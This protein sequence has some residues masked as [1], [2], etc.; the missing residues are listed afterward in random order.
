[1]KN[2]FFLKLAKKYRW[3]LS[4]HVL[5][6]V[7]LLTLPPL[8]PL[9][10][11]TIVPSYTMLGI[12]RG[13]FTVSGFLMVLSGS[14]SDRIGERKAILLEFF[15]VPGFLVLMSLSPSYLFLLLFAGGFGLSKILYHPAGLSFLSKSIDEE[16]RGEAI[17]LHESMGNLGAGIAFIAVGSLGGWLGWRPALVLVA[18]PILLLGVSNWLLGGRLGKDVNE[19]VEEDDPPSDDTD[20]SIGKT[21]GVEKEKLSSFYL[22]IVSSVIGGIGF[23][24]FVTFLASFLNQVYGLSTGLAGLLVGSSYLLG[25]FG[26][27][28]GG[29]ISDR[30][31]E[32]LSYTIF[33]VLASVPIMLVVLVD[34]PYFL[35]IPIL[36]AC[37]LLRSLGNP[38]DKSLLAEH[39]S[40]AGRGR[41]YGSLFTSYTLGSFTSGPLFGFL[42]DKF[43]MESAFLLIPVLFVVG[44]VVRYQ[45][46]RYP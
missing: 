7:S 3:L 11:G 14:L 12:L 27:L 28:Y 24:A 10:K 13:V 31:G 4:F 29:R 21:L 41:G 2:G 33:M 40:N 16:S 15:L 37:F 43:R 36:A 26:N 39:S 34:L 25:F 42:I 23:G 17:G 22:Q 30:L 45:V 32:V 5:H 6:H 46:K 44:A 18:V 35:L 20:G 1:M 38:A 9:L 8:F 19:E